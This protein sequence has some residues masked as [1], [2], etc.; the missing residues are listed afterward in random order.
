[1]SWV[2]DWA[3]AARRVGTAM[4]RMDARMT[5][6]RARRSVSAPKKGAEMETA[7][8]AAETVSPAEALVTWKSRVKSGSRGWVQ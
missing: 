8:V 7:I 4:P 6:R 5:R 1:M 2:R 3:V